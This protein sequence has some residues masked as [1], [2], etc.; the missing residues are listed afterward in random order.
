MDEN[1]SI[2]DTSSRSVPVGTASDDV[3]EAPDTVNRLFDAVALD[4]G[5][6]AWCDS[7]LARSGRVW[8]ENFPRREETW[9]VVIA[10]V[11]HAR[12]VEQSDP[13]M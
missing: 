3:D 12:N 2:P 4:A 8:H 5:R 9:E 11:R 1:G 13:C 6:C 7:A 10:V